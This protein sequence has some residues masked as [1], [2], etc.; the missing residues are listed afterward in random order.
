MIKVI[1]TMKNAFILILFVMYFISSLSFAGSWFG[2][3]EGDFVGLGTFLDPKSTSLHHQYEA[4]S[5]LF[6]KIKSNPSVIEVIKT[7]NLKDPVVKQDLLKIDFIREQKNNFLKKYVRSSPSKDPDDSSPIP[8]LPEIQVSFFTALQDVQK[9]LNSSWEIFSEEKFLNSLRYSMPRGRQIEA[10]RITLLKKFVNQITLPEIT[11][12][13]IEDFHRA[14]ETYD[15]DPNHK[16]LALQEVE[17]LVENFE[18][19][20][21]PDGQNKLSFALNQSNPSNPEEKSI[22]DRLTSFLDEDSKAALICTS[23]HCREKISQVKSAQSHF[24][25]RMTQSSGGVRKLNSTLEE[26]DRF[27]LLLR[28]DYAH[29]ISNPS[30]IKRDIKNHTFK[31]IYQEDQATFEN[32]QKLVQENPAA[33]SGEGS[34][35]L[36]HSVQSNFSFLNL[37]RDFTQV[38]LRLALKFFDEGSLNELENHSQLFYG[39]IIIL[40]W[41]KASTLGDQ[42]LKTNAK[43][44][45]IQFLGSYSEYKWRHLQ[46]GTPIPTDYFETQFNQVITG[47]FPELK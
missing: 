37:Y 7:S 32:A 30:G 14:L 39:D 5:L 19:K 36:L 31:M 38:P 41:K 35:I 9:I 10:R 46:T 12:K 40:L 42:K 21:I 13:Q 20:T 34:P 3:L 18:K 8:P 11:P 2:I 43:D 15:L 27:V 47:L 17:L 4:T 6:A 1:K 33:Q 28:Q 16:T 23:R 29:L 25:Q 45:I 44:Q 26:F 22:R 24:H